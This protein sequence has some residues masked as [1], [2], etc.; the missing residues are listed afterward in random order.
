MIMGACSE[1]ERLLIDAERSTREASLNE[2]KRVGED[3][4]YDQMS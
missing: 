3:A 1:P 4:T 2:V